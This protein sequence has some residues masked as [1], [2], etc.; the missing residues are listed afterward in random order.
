M[1]L[2]AN[3][4]YKCASVRLNCGGFEDQ[5]GAQRIAEELKNSF[6]LNCQLN[7]VDG[8]AVVGS[9]YGQILAAVGLVSKAIGVLEKAA[10]AYEVLQQADQAA[11]LR[12]FAVKLREGGQ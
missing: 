9:L 7:R 5:E 3:T 11:Q 2:I 10:I 4:L 8:I 12:E 1:D 6:D